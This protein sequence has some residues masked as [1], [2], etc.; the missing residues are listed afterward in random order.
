MF[1]YNKLDKEIG[2][3]ERKL[4]FTDLIVSK[5]DKKGMITYANPAFLKISGYQT[6]ELCSQNHN[7]IRH[8]D[9]PR[10]IFSYMWQELEK[11]NHFYGF[12]K[13]LTKEGAFYWIFAY[14]VPDYDERGEVIGYHSERR[15]PNPKAI[16]DIVNLY[17]MMK[18]I[19][20]KK[21]IDSAI[22]YMQSIVSN[23]AKDYNNYIYKLQ[24]QD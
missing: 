18:Q 3:E 17:N 22:E 15:S 2:Y 1:N 11:G 14:M 4:N 16:P 9:M 24:N 8:P 7:I 13:N 19:E 20:I 6:K 21:D 5:T 23:K 12:V 10:A